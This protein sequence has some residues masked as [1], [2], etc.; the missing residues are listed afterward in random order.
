MINPLVSITQNV[1]FRTAKKDLQKSL[2]EE[3]Y[4]Q[5]RLCLYLSLRNKT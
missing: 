4:T 1:S 2:M 3:S 5:I